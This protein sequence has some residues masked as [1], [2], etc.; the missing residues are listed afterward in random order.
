M[1]ERITDLRAP[2]LLDVVHRR[3]DREPS[4]QFLLT[5]SGATR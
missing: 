4:R 2:V 1:N 5:G 3:L